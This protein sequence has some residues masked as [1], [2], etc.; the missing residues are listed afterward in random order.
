MRMEGH[1]SHTCAIAPQVR[2]GGVPVLP[3]LLRLHDREGVPE[4]PAGPRPGHRQRE[5]RELRRLRG[6][7]L[8]RGRPEQAHAPAPGQPLLLLR[9][10]HIPHG[11]AEEGESPAR[12]RLRCVLSS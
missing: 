3:V 8:L 9:H 11:P 4:A 7:P 1:W 10:L 6:R 12:P 5:S 2:E